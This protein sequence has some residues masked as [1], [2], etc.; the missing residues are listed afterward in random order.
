[1]S[2]GMIAVIEKAIVSL[3]EQDFSASSERA[4]SNELMK[5]SVGLRMQR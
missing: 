2:T 4:F 3:T 1:M 5:I